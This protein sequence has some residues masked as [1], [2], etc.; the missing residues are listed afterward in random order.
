MH[1]SYVVITILA[2]A[3]NIYAASLNFVGAESV[4]IVADRVQVP[5]TWMV[6][7]GVLLSAGA[8]GL[9]I[10]FKVPALGQAAA[11]GLIL[12]FVCAVAAHLR[13]HDDQIGGAVG[14]LGMAVCALLGSLAYHDHW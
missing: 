11:A 6:P 3:A 9:L 14:F 10:G 12:Y 13:A 7:L 1:I 2:A 8:G 4:K 5:R